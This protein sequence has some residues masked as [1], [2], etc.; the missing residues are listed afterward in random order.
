MRNNFTLL[1]NQGI[2]CGVV[3]GCPYF[4]ARETVATIK[5]GEEQLSD[6]LD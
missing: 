1:L 4:Y 6:S 5:E 3:F 2:F